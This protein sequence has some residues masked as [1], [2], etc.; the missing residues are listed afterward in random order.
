MTNKQT[1]ATAAP[2]ERPTP[3]LLLRRFKLMDEIVES[4]RKSYDFISYDFLKQM[5]L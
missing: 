3:E 4:V 1:Q 2:E 5:F